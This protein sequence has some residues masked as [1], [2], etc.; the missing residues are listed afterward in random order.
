MVGAVLRFGASTRSYKV[1]AIDDAAAAR[2]AE[3]LYSIMSDPEACKPKEV[4]TTIFVGNLPFEASQTEVHG[5]I[6]GCRAAQKEGR[7]RGVT[8]VDLGLCQRIS[9][10]RLPVDKETNMPRGIAFVTCRSEAV[11]AA[12]CKKDGSTFEGRQLSINIAKEESSSSS[13]SSSSGGAKG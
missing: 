5:F 2:R 4:P 6:C 7:G 1:A 10:I 13:S 8:L 12:A 11:A 3:A 9:A